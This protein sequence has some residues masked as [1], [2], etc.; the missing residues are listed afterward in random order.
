MEFN[1]ITSNPGVLN[2]KPVLKGTRISVEIIMEWL[3][4]GASVEAIYNNYPH[5][6]KGSVQQALNYAAQF[7]KNEILIEEEIHG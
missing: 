4:T 7:S 2:G 3:A 5:F 1:L 6:P